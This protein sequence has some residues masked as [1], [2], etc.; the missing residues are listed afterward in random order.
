MREV[1]K[2]RNNNDKKTI[3]NESISIESLGRN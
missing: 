1:I 3:R 2:N